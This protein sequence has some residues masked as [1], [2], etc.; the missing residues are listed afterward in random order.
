[1]ATAFSCDTA[2]LVEQF[3][4]VQSVAQATAAEECGANNREAWRSALLRL[5]RRRQFRGRLGE[6]SKAVSAYLGWQTGTGDVERAF[7]THEGLFCSHRRKSMSRQREQ[8][9]LTLATDYVQRE[10]DDIIES[11]ITIWKKLFYNANGRGLA[12][13]GR[14]RDVGNK[15]RLPACEG[16]LTMT[17]LLSKR[18]RT[19]EQLTRASGLPVASAAELEALTAGTWTPALEKEANHMKDKRSVR[20]MEFLANGGQ[21][22]EHLLGG[23]SRQ[24]IVDIFE[25][26]QKRLA[27]ERQKKNIVRRTA[28]A[29]RGAHDLTG[30]AVKWDPDTLTC[31]ATV[32]ALRLRTPLEIS[33]CQPMKQRVANL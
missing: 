11:A 18:R 5:R 31:V 24:E 16:R 32:R 14:R 9:I 28:F 6:I 1:M 27:D 30:K 33:G 15:R 26:N 19:T 29:P 7:S 25:V 12:R 3:F 21:L 8:D 23:L 20:I 4:Q 13:E 22:P 17:R 2:T 10:A